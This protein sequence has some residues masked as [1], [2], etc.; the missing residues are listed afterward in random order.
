MDTRYPDPPTSC[1]IWQPAVE[2]S[3]STRW[4][5]NPNQA[6]RHS[7]HNIWSSYEHRFTRSLVALDGAWGPCQTTSRSSNRLGYG[8]GQGSCGH[9]G[10]FQ[11][12]APYERHA[13]EGIATPG[14]LLLSWMGSKRWHTL[15]CLR[16]REMTVSVGPR[17]LVRALRGLLVEFP[18]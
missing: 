16:W 5:A 4:L 1:G 8:T 7:P 10:N 15:P 11:P 18:Q 2:L 12:E 17:L 6:R 13:K 9:A 14:Q 3:E